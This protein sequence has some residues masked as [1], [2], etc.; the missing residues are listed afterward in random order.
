[1]QEMALIYS[2]FATQED[3]IAA[4]R[5]LIAE[6]L[7]TC[8]NV[9]APMIAMYPAD[10]EIK[11]APETG[12]F[13]KAHPPVKDRLIKRLGEIH[14]YDVP[15]IIEIVANTTPAFAKWLETRVW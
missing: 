12:A 4:L 13:F 9:F 15:C 6:E 1:M 8:G 7:V 11:Q 5:T 14:P 3:A 2:T 10:G